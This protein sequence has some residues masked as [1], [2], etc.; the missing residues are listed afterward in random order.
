MV[1][2][3]KNQLFH[4][5][6]RWIILHNLYIF[7]WSILRIK[8]N[9]SHKSFKKVLISFNWNSKWHSR[10]PQDCFKF[11]FKQNKVFKHPSNC[12][13]AVHVQV[14]TK[15]MFVIKLRSSQCAEHSARE[16]ERRR[17]RV[18]LLKEVSRFMPIYNF[19]KFN[20][21]KLRNAGCLINVLLH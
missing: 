19:I 17:R 8:K 20:V 1:D 3:F 10:P 5:L 9:Q 12:S 6:C 14:K 18:L 13:S 2:P 7:Y 11:P 16:R 21:I 15:F 4:M